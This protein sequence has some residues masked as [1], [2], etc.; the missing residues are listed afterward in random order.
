M[1][2][3]RIYRRPRRVVCEQRRWF[4]FIL[5]SLYQVNGG[6]ELQLTGNAAFGI[7]FFQEHYKWVDGC[8]FKKIR[9]LPYRTL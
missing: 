5:G 9:N 1:L 8:Q 7:W 2:F 4:V 3:L 6:L